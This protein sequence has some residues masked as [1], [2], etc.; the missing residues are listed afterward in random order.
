M[1]KDNPPVCRRC[2]EKITGRSV[3]CSHCGCILCGECARELSIEEE[4][5]YCPGCHQLTSLETLRETCTA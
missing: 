4:N 3:S 2:G 1:N 5:Y